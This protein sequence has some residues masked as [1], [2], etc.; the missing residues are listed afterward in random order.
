[1][2]FQNIHYI[3][4]VLTLIIFWI[5]ANLW[6]L[7]KFNSWVLEYWGFKRSKRSLFGNVIYL[8]GFSFLLFGLLDIRGKEENIKGKTSVQKTIILIDTSTSM[9]AEDIR[10]NRLK[11]AV[12]LARHFIKKSVGHS[13]SVVVF[14][15]SQKKIVPFTNDIDLIDARLQSIESLKIKNAGTN[16]NLAIQESIQYFKTSGEENPIGNILVFSDAEDHEL[17]I[18]LNI[19]SNISIG[20]V[21]IGTVQGSTIPLR[22][23]NFSL[24]KVKEFDGKPAITKLDEK[25]LKRISESVKNFK[26]WVATSYGVPTEDI[27][28]Y[29]N[30]SYSIKLNDDTFK[31][32]PVKAPLVIIPSILLIILG[33]ILK[34]FKNFTTLVAFIL[35]STN[36]FA[37]DQQ[38]E[39]PLSDNANLIIEKLKNNEAETEDKLNL[40]DELR[41]SKKNHH[42]NKLYNE[43][44]SNAEINE[45]NKNDFFN[46][47]TNLLETGQFRKAT[48]VL[49][50]L[51]NYAVRNNDKKTLEN[52]NKN[53]AKALQVQEEKQKQQNNKK[54]NQQN[55][56]QQEQDQQN[57]QSNN[58]E[59]SGQQK[60]NDKNEE[61][62]KNEDQNK[63]KNKDKKN[64]NKNEQKNSQKNQNDQKELTPEEAKKMKK[65]LPAMLKQLMSEDRQLQQK[66]LDTSTEERRKRKIKDW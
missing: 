44:L 29:F 16:L 43:T 59:S 52:I 17:A 15:D 66:L 3:P 51:K 34:Y 4:I 27:I 31:I 40:A 7:K 26:Y 33:I 42:A 32:K 8:L 2:N 22:D 58:S 62:N 30:N 28:E 56:D 24:T 63:D 46:Y 35:I 61:Q 9:L 55:K 39:I 65:M 13:L 54:E 21:G 50:N 48:E 45:E 37:D 49:S 36:L 38:Q 10:P 6:Q 5:I 41:I 1:M 23:E 25:N 11:K 19:P 20:F 47:G 64:D 53:I 14:S 57:N 12:F 60:N 18:D